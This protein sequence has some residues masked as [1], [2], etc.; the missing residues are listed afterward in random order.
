MDVRTEGKDEEADDRCGSS[1]LLA[2]YRFRFG[3]GLRARIGWGS[4]PFG[5]LLIMWKIWVQDYRIT[6]NEAAENSVAAGR[7]VRRA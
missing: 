6:A 5:R 4:A 1:A 3:P 7:G 2:N